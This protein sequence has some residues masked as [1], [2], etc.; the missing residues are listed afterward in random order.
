MMVIS[1]VS[2]LQMLRPDFS[3]FVFLPSVGASGGILSLEGW[4]GFP[5]ELKDRQLFGLNSVLPY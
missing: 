5:W 2:V 4:L 1:H 3:N